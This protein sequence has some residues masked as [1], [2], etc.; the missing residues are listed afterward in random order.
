[1]L[2]YSAGGSNSSRAHWKRRGPTWLR[3]TTS[4]KQAPWAGH[5][6]WL[7][8][9]LPLSLTCRCRAKLHTA[10]GTWCLQLPLSSP[11]TCLCAKVALDSPG[12][13]F[14]QKPLP[15][16]ASFFSPRLL[17]GKC[18]L[19]YF[20]GYY[21]EGCI[22]KGI[23]C[24]KRSGCWTSWYLVSTAYCPT[25]LQ[26]SSQKG[27]GCPVGEFQGP[28]EGPHVG[29]PLSFPNP[30]L[31]L[32]PDDSLDAQ[33]CCSPA[34]VP[35]PDFPGLPQATPPP[36]PLSADSRLQNASNTSVLSYI[37]SHCHLL[38]ASSQE[39]SPSS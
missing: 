27:E 39:P 37:N 16:G 14:L 22:L 18:V 25:P 20:K 31:S 32:S 36:A 19:I 26:G 7:R 10:R 15:K 13:I 30:S 9:P 17:L 5:Q 35:S 38:L 12:G 21:L 3:D 4:H 8:L 23:M 1:M 33:S 28:R 11:E 24:V 6:V 29:P 34:Q 2:T